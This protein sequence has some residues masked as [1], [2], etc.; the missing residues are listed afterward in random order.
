MTNLEHFTHLI[1]NRFVDLRNVELATDLITPNVLHEMAN[2][3]PKLQSLTLGK[4]D[5][6]L[7]KKMFL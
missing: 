1:G 3:C 2:K 6:L 4:I 5:P 7:R